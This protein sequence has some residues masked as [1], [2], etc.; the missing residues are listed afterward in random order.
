MNSIIKLPASTTCLAEMDYSTLLQSPKDAN[1]GS[2][3]KE[4]IDQKMRR[5]LL[6]GRVG[7]EVT[8][9]LLNISCG[10]MCHLEK[11]LQ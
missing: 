7:T 5:K 6:S 4:T 10:W 1:Q 8:S 9:N 2:E 11:K 3:E